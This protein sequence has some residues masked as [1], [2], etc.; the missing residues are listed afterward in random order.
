MIIQKSYYI[1]LVILGLLGFNCFGYTDQIA[2]AAHQ[3][4]NQKALVRATKQG[5]ESLVIELLNLGIP[6]NKPDSDGWTPLHWAACAGNFDIAKILLDDGNITYLISDFRGRTPLDIAKVDDAKGKPAIRMLL[7]KRNLPVVQLKLKS[8]TPQ[9][10]PSRMP[11]AYID[12]GDYSRSR[13]YEYLSRPSAYDYAEY[14]RRTGTPYPHARDPRESA[15]KR[16][17]TFKEESFNP[18]K[19]QLRAPSILPIEGLE[20]QEKK[21]TN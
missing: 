14:E 4:E 17:P 11:S 19:I 18:Y 2:A 6:A 12:S 21:A 20:E 15:Y 9:T 5:N 16:W 3:Q 8:S 7:E 1:A 13:S 10:I